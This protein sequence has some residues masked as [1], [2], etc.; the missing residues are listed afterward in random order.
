MKVLFVE[1]E[2]SFSWNVIDALPFDRSEITVVS[3]SDSLRLQEALASTDALVIGPGPMDPERAGIV[4]LVTAA[5]ARRIPTLG[6][7]LG[8][9]AVGLAFGARL[10][11]VEP[12]HGKRATIELRGSRFFSSVRGPI[13]A[14]RY[15]SLALTDVVAPLMLV[16]ETADGV[17]M[18]IEHTTLP[19][20]GLQF[21]PDSFGT[22]RGREILASFFKAVA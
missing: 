19:I 10:I 1:N 21:H 6:I 17:A 13:S 8:H 14:M 15:H 7:C 5:A 11:R 16:A 9:Q 12:C 4:D 18:A 20:A 2:D 3:G 22:P